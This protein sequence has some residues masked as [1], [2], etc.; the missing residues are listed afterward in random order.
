MGRTQSQR[1]GEGAGTCGHDAVVVKAERA[2][3]S[4]EATGRLLVRARR[5][6]KQATSS[7]PVHEKG[8]KGTQGDT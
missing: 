4:S 6:P 1:E 5:K 7:G 3:A 8:M 2:T